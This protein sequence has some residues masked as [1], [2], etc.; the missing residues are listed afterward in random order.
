[1]SRNNFGKF[2]FVVIVVLWALYEIYPPR[3]KDLVQHFGERARARDAT[4][5]DIFN[6]AKELQ[7]ERPDRA[8][9]DLQDAIGT[10]EIARYFPF[11]DVKSELKPT[12][13]I[14]SRLQREAAGRIKLGLDLQGGTSFLVEMDAS[15]LD[16]ID[17]VTNSLGQIETITN[18]VNEAELQGA[19][20]HAVEVLR[21][22]VDR[23]GVSEPVIQP[24]GN[25]RIMVQLPGLS[26]AERES[27]MTQIQR[28]AFLEF[29][30]V[31]E[32]SDELIKNGEVPPY[33]ELLKHMEKSRDGKEYIEAVI[34]KKKPALTGSAIKS[35]MAV[36]GNLGQPEIDFTLNPE[37]AAVFADLTRENVGHRLAIVLDSNLY[38]APVIQSAIETGR[39]QI[40]GRFDPKDAQELANVLENP[41]KAPLHIVYSSDVD[42][43]LGKDSVRSGVNAAVIGVIAVAVFM[44]VYY[45]F[46]GLVA[47]AA[48]MLNIV[49][50]M[51]VMCSIGTTLTLP[52]IAGI[53]LTIGMAVDANVLI[54]ERIREEQAAGKSMRGA[55]AAGYDKAFGTIF[56][57]NLTTL[58]SSVIL[59]FMGTGSVK[60]FGVTLTIGVTVSMFT[61]LVVTRLIFDW[62]LEKG[63][64]KTI[65]MWQFPFLH[66]TKFNFMRW[67]IPAFAVS[68]L[69]IVIGNGYGIFWRG[70]DVLGV[71]FSGGETIT[72]SFDQKQDV[73]VDKIRESV[74][75]TGVGDALIAYQK[76]ITG[77]QRTLSI[78]VKAEQTGAP[79]EDVA[80]KVITR[81]Q[82]DFQAAQFSPLSVNKV[83]ATVGKE[84]LKTAVLAGLLALFGILIYVAFRYE[85]SF[86]VG[87]VIAIVHDILMTTGWYFLAGRQMNA[88][89]VAALLTII[90]FSINDTIVI[91]DRIREDLKLG[92][93]GTFREV[94]N[95]ALNQT[96]SR[97]IITSGTVFLATLSLY[98]FGGGVINDF[99]FAF[100]VGILTGTY[101]S[102]YIAS[103]I[104]LWWHKGQRPNIGSGALNVQAEK[105]V[106]AKA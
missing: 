24:A 88:T 22:R 48:L 80:Q 60:G 67:A 15:R 85:F 74:A 43:T 53:V 73:G 94:M 49:I 29:R 52:G 47:N 37:G 41:L 2:I 36:R 99:A 14:L 1:M 38:S 21:R 105:T 57:S 69:L 34:V 30:M 96:L 59:I 18:H 65:R 12:F 42:P 44:L 89:T 64:L 98:I 3:N 23:F 50:L 19:L 77:N 13:A 56:D 92:L 79:G 63:W 35:A 45:L 83:G 55:L 46:A 71:E 61:A 26:Q 51:G 16:R 66:G 10:N 100:L 86:A 40:T 106:A 31:H 54:F 91:F 28:A 27:A 62:L 93:R 58:I 78:T 75:K 72:L 87:A 103:A 7:K 84:I 4:F 82:S 68:W 33:Y 104:V 5:T 9:A 102:I 70:S 95:Q 32:Q 90:G 25:N 17:T 39:G 81:L 6:R 20:S 11:F 101:S 97:T 76:E 8:F